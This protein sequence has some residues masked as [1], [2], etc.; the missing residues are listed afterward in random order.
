MNKLGE[1]GDTGICEAGRWLGTAANEFPGLTFPNVSFLI[2]ETG[3]VFTP[4]HLS[5][6]VRIK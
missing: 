5:G 3:T 4:T 1:G 2:C 6:V